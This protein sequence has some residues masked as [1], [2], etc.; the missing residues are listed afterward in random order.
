MALTF[1][2][3]PNEDGVQ[4]MPTVAFPP[5]FTTESGEV[6]LPFAWF[7]ATFT[8]PQLLIERVGLLPVFKNS[9]FL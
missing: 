1:L 9:F 7:W 6:H 5:E 8:S 4:V 2:V 3:K